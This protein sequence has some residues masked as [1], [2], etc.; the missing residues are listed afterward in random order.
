MTAPAPARRG[1]PRATAP[2][3]PDAREPIASLIRKSAKARRK[4]AP[5]TWAHRMLGENLRALRIA[6]AWMDQKPG[7]AAG[8]GRDDLARALRTLAALIARTAKT[9][10]KFRPGTS[11]HTLQRNRLRALRAAQA[12]L[13]EALG[14]PRPRGKPASGKAAGGP[15]E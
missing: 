12:G 3:G 11:P 8:A 9:R 1:R 7:R 4:L 2:A 10:G 6:A 13:R 5:G 15:P 14:T